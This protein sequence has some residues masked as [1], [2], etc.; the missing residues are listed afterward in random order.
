MNNMNL[1]IIIPVYNVQT[2]L[3]ECIYSILR[4]KLEV[5]YEIILIND[6][7]TDNSG[8]ICEDFAKKYKQ[9]KI[10]NQNNKGVSYAR[11]LGLDIIKGKY[12]FF[13]D[14]D[15]LLVPYK[16]E[17][18]LKIMEK[19]KFDILEFNHN[20]LIDENLIYG[21]D[22]NNIVIYND[23]DVIMKNFC[24]KKITI[25]L[26][27][28]IISK[29]IIDN[30][31]FDINYSHFED[32]LFLYNILKKCNVF[33]HVNICGYTYRIRSGS[34]SYALFKESYFQILEVDKIIV[35]DSKKNYKNIAYLFK[36]NELES[37]LY[38]YKMLTKTNQYYLF[39][40]QYKEI[41]SYI[42][43]TNTKIIKL[44]NLR[45]KI[46]Y[47]LIKYNQYLYKKLFTLYIRKK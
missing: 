42:E 41:H 26:W 4:Q 45:K 7:S 47:F 39:P 32:K 35:N 19:N 21:N 46:E 12:V 20:K 15:D 22:N 2:Y 31:R 28:K 3:S 5:E 34:A 1:S 27:D 10:I 11:N 36:K 23:T 30:I 13:V 17:K 44:L 18:L 16:L 33:A 37:H 6:G 38:L 8:K 14:G 29:K 25:S 43:Q 24:E 9:I 40:R